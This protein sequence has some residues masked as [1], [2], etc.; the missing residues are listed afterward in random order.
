MKNEQNEEE[1]SK[2]TIFSDYEKCKILKNTT[3]SP[4]QEQVVFHRR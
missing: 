1:I 3:T 2:I 4:P